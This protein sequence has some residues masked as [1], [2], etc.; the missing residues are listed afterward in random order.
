[1]IVEGVNDEYQGHVETIYFAVLGALF[2]K[3]P[4]EV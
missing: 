1:M 2:A 3:I 4:D